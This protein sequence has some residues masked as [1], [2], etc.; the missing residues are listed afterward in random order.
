MNMST[1]VE[2][3]PMEILIEIFSF[4][5]RQ[6]Y[7]KTLT[8]NRVCYEASMAAQHLEERR[9][10]A[11]RYACRHHNIL[12]VKRCLADPKVIPHA[13]YLRGT[14]AFVE[15]CVFGC[16]D[17]VQLLLNDNR[18]DL[19]KYNNSALLNAI[20][21]GNVTIIQLLLKDERVRSSI[22]PHFIQKA[23]FFKKYHVIPLLLAYVK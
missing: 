5:N 15:A 18:I 6:I 19:A 3:I 1:A 13:T 23:I 8:L 4:L 10:H 14:N 17:I 9:S 2:F 7:R 20:Y 21:R 16:V 12:L 22:D 11:L